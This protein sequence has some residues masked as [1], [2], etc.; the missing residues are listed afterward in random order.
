MIEKVE[1]EFGFFPKVFKGFE[2]NARGFI[3]LGNQEWPP[4]SLL[5]E[6]LGS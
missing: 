2:G 6:I 4:F 5:R 1:K 3:S